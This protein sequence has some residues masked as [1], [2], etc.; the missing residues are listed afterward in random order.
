M[1]SMRAMMT[2]CAA[3]D[4]DNTCIYNF[5][6]LPVHDPKSFEEDK[7]ILLYGTGVGFNVERQYIN[8][9]PEVHDLYDSENT[10]DV[11][12]RNDG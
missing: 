7:Y 6:Y 4:R 9:I 3:A 5:S 2:A 12:D 8:K 1:P 10:K 11:Q